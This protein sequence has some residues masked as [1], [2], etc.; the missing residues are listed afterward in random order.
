LGVWHR[1]WKLISRFCPRNPGTAFLDGDWF[2]DE[3]A[4]LAIT[5]ARQPS[6]HRGSRSRV[7]AFQQDTGTNLRQSRPFN[8][9]LAPISGT[10]L[11]PI[12]VGFPRERVGPHPIRVGLHGER[13]RPRPVRVGLRGERV[14]P[15][16][17][18][19]GLRG[20]RVGKRSVRI[21]KCPRAVHLHT[22]VFLQKKFCVSQ[23]QRLAAIASRSKPVVRSRGVPLNDS[24]VTRLNTCG[25]WGA[26]PQE[27]RQ[28]RHQ[29]HSRQHCGA[30]LTETS[31]RKCRRPEHVLQSTPQ[32]H[33]EQHSP[34]TPSA[35]SR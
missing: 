15:R 12:G 8:K 29:R 6:D 2:H 18:R 21:E 27:Q 22:V 33:H 26:D 9:T 17:V 34:T 7:S 30:P 14:G 4:V 28:Q 16:P 1:S 13:I 5:F 31:G 11:R 35:P 32:P 19:V 23:A 25:C 3:M 20:E 10:N 24:A